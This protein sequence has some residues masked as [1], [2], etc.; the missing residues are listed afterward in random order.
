MFVRS[1]WWP[2]TVFFPP[3]FWKAFGLWTRKLSCTKMKWGCLH[4][5]AEGRAGALSHLGPPALRPG[6][7][8]GPQG[9]PSTL[10]RLWGWEGSLWGADL[11]WN[12]LPGSCPECFF[13]FFNFFWSKVDWEYCISCKCTTKWIRYTY[14]ISILFQILF[15]YRLLQSTESVSLCAPGGPCWLSIPYTAVCIC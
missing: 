2:R 14:R 15:P 3:S 9:M 6:G 11:P 5:Q 8:P 12:E 13:F 7:L 1:I 4:R 10:G